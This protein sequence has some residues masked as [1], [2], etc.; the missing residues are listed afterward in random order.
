MNV[1]LAR[2]LRIKSLLI[3]LSL[4]NKC[5]L[6]RFIAALEKFK[7]NSAKKSRLETKLSLS[8]LKSI[9]NQKKEKKNWKIKFGAAGTM[10]VERNILL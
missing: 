1:L 8:G 5:I 2:K 6:S 4:K 3:F 9:L 10:G 7:F